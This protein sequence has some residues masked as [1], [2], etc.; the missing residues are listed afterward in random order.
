MQME[1][2]KVVV[3]QGDPGTIDLTR[4]EMVEEWKRVLDR[5]PQIGE[6]R[7]V[8]PEKK[9]MTFEDYSMKNRTYRYLHEEPLYPFGYGLSY[10]KFAYESIQMP[11]KITARTWN[12]LASSCVAAA[13]WA[14]PTP[15]QHNTTLLPPSCPS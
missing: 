13:A 3:F 14:L 8:D 15:A 4:E 2:K 11:E 7:I 10:T 9:R 12:R 6:Y 1:K 5:I